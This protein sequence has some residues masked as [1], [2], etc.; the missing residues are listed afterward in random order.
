MSVDHRFKRNSIE[1]AFLYYITGSTVHRFFLVN[2]EEQVS[3]FGSLNE[4]RTFIALDAYSK[5]ISLF[6][7][8][9]LIN[10]F[11][12]LTIIKFHN[13]TIHLFYTFCRERFLNIIIV[14]LEMTQQYFLNS[15][16]GYTAY[17]I[18]GFGLFINLGEQRYYI[19]TE[20]SGKEPVVSLFGEII[21]L[22]LLQVYILPCV[23][24]VFKILFYLLQVESQ[25]HHCNQFLLQIL[26]NNSLR[27]SHCFF[28][29][30]FI[31]ASEIHL[32]I[33]SVL[34]HRFAYCPAV[35]LHLR[36]EPLLS[37]LYALIFVSGLVDNSK[38]LLE[39]DNN[40]T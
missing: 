35:A 13:I 6:I 2:S 38:I 3:T 12:R 10:R 40:I 34:M 11:M 23:L 25:F 31:D 5:L 21:N 7:F 15:C 22:Y 30:H 18:L 29:L 33:N 1:Y 26:V 32:A 8:S 37:V 19:V 9:Y 36:L 27:I 14:C 39:A 24:V 28:E 17:N 16:I 20:T 4:L